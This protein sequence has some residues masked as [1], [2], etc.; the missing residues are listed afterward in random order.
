MFCSKKSGTASDLS[1]IPHKSCSGSICGG[2]KFVHNRCTVARDYCSGT[3]G[4]WLP[5]VSVCQSMQSIRFKKTSH[6]SSSSQISPSP[7]S[8]SS[9]VQQKLFNE[10]SW[11]TSVPE[12]YKSYLSQ[13]AE[14]WS[15]F[16]RFNPSVVQ[17][18]KSFDPAWDGISLESFDQFDD[19]ISGVIAA[20]GPTRGV[21]LTGNAVKFN[22]T[23]F[24][25][26]VNIHYQNYFSPEEWSDIMAHE[27]GHA[28]G[29]GVF[30][31]PD[32]TNITGGVPPSDNFLDGNSYQNAQRAYNSMT[33]TTRQKIPL[34]NEGGNGTAS[35][36]WE[37]NYRPSTAQGS[38]GVGYPG[39][40]NELM[41]GFYSQ[42]QESMIS[43]LSI[44]TLVD[45]GY[46]LIEEGLN[47]GVPNLS[48]GTGLI[49]NMGIK[50]KCQLPKKVSMTSLDLPLSLFAKP[51]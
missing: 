41:V 28:L 29:I 24:A 43:D 25:V 11:A 40:T 4:A 15:R 21:D 32:I 13:A 6:H 34:E 7:S 10:N 30:W 31:S 36:H 26:E 51:T 38:M 5:V 9:Q 44:K 39:L 48:I 50:L 18:V 33:L 12:P 2:W 22:S 8:S 17:S 19:S 49:G 14:R 3:S 35:A 46:D 47:E 45:F 37:N 42:G 16:I 1:E 27:L 20:C 23:Q